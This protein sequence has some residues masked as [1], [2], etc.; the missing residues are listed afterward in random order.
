MYV[1]EVNNIQLGIGARIRYLPL[2]HDLVQHLPLPKPVLLLALLL[3]IDHDLV[4][5]DHAIRTLCKHNLVFVKQCLANSRRLDLVHLICFEVISVDLHHNALPVET[6]HFFFKRIVEGSHREV[7]DGAVAESNCGEVGRCLREWVVDKVVVLQ[8]T[9]L[10]K[11]VEYFVVFEEGAASETIV[12]EGEGHGARFDAEMAVDIKLNNDFI[13]RVYV[14]EPI[15]VVHVGE[16]EERTLLVLFQMA[17]FEVL[18]I[19]RMLVDPR[20][21]IHIE[22]LDPQHLVFIPEEADETLVLLN[23]YQAYDCVICREFDFS[24]QVLECS[25]C[26]EPSLLLC[27]AL[28]FLFLLSIPLGIGHIS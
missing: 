8:F 2:L 10:E 21:I 3:G 23:H 12:E 20:L 16:R 6:V 26:L 9:P 22:L 4:K 7:F 18:S 19:Y 13:V 15:T 24:C 28:L 17:G 5:Q 25:A 1:I 27:R 11:V 14:E